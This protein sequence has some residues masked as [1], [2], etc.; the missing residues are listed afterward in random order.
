[1]F[2]LKS[3][4]EKFD[5]MGPDARRQMRLRLE[6]LRRL[7]IFNAVLIAINTVALVAAVMQGWP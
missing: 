7:L 1:M 5:E 4:A 2:S 6:R 3:P